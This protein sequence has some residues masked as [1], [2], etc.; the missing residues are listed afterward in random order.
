M[1]RRL[2]WRSSRPSHANVVDV[3]RDNGGTTAEQ[4][5]R[6]GPRFVGH[7][8]HML[9]RPSGLGRGRCQHDATVA[10]AAR[11]VCLLATPHAVTV[12]LASNQVGHVFGGQR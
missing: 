12:R 6:H 7:A 1:R 10:R 2:T 9:L 5:D 11:W 4:D 8:F 3:R